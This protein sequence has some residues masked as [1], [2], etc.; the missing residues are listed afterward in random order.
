M[1]SQQSATYATSSSSSSTANKTSYIVRSVKFL[2]LKFDGFVLGFT[3]DYI[4]RH[5][6]HSESI[7]AA[8]CHCSGLL[9]P[10]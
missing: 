9:A 2:A 6:F 1:T 10:T 7:S 5:A 4:Y 8:K 3:I